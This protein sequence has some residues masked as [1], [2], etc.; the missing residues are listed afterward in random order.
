MPGLWV[1]AGLPSPPLAS[2]VASPQAGGG[3]RPPA[4]MPGLH[5]LE[6]I[7]DVDVLT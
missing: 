1:A 3:A 4:A 7:L 5:Q 6:N 2:T